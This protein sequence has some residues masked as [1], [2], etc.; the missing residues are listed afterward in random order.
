MG[1]TAYQDR[2]GFFMSYTHTKKFRG[3]LVQCDR[4]GRAGE[5]YYI[6]SHKMKGLHIDCPKCGPHFRSYIPNLNLPYKYSSSFEKQVLNKV[7][8]PKV[9]N[10]E[11][12]TIF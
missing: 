10:S 12:T 2:A 8:A 11:Q 9:S 3:Q 7:P 5:A 1:L 4:C 6:L